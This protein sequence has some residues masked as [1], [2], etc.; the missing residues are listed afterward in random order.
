MYK[1]LAKQ[2]V[3]QWLA[4][5]GTA[6]LI[7][8]ACYTMV[9]QSTRLAANDQPIALGQAILSQLENG[10]VPNDVVPAQSINLKNNTNVFA[11]IADGEQHVLASSATLDGQ[12]PLPPKGVFTYAAAHG[13]DTF[14]WQPAGNV[15]LA[16]NVIAYGK[17]PD[18]GF[19]ITGQSL[20][21]PEKR[22]AVYGGL[23]L[24]AWIAVL[25]WTSL[26]LLLPE[27]KFTRSK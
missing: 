12:S 19:I 6:T 16:T 17:A 27:R 8:G 18:N 23:A 2:P 15:R 1:L 9:Q 4:L 20:A 13:A 14:T 26:V 21:Q 25:A 11:V 22:I 7:L 3:R 24:A 10:A 5:A